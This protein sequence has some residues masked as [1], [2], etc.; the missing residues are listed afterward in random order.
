MTRRVLSFLDTFGRLVMC[1]R[2]IRRAARMRPCG[3]WVLY[4]ATPDAR[5]VSEVGRTT[6]EAQAASWVAEG[7]LP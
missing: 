6:V 2:D 4:R 5:D 7:A 3:T 1:T